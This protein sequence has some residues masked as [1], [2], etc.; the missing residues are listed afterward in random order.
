M[1]DLKLNIGSMPLYLGK[2]LRILKS[3]LKAHWE[4]ERSLHFRFEVWFFFLKQHLCSIVKPTAFR[5]QQIIIKKH[6]FKGI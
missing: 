5:C 6:D 4:D 3:R 2:K 1:L